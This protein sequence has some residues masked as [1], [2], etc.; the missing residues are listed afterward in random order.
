MFLV[1]ICK[2]IAMILNLKKIHNLE[3]CEYLQIYFL[4]NMYF[5][6]TLSI[7]QICGAYENSS[8]SD[9]HLFFTLFSFGFVENIA[10]K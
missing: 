7:V 2:V 4:V 10:S 6:H 8:N 1:K 9:E 5:I 3:A